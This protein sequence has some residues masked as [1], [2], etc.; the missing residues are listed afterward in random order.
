MF[1]DGLPLG[2][3]RGKRWAACQPERIVLEELDLFMREIW[4]ELEAVL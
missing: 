2:R 1:L 3:L 4:P